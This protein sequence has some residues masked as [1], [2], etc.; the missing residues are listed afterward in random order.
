MQAFYF[1]VTY[2]FIFLIALLPFPILYK[3]SDF[4]YH[5]LRL[6][7]YR[8]EIV[9]KNLQN[10]FP[11]KSPSEIED[12]SQTYFRYLCDLT[13]ETLKTITM[14]SAEAKKHCVF[15]SATWLDDLYR[16]KKSIIIIMGHYGNWEW[17]GPSFSLNT[18]YQLIVIY[19]PLSNT[20]FENMM[21]TMRTKFGTCITPVNQTLRKMVACKDQVTA[22]AFIADQTA[23]QRDA[24]WTTFLNQET[25]VFT[26][27]EKLAIKFNYP[28]VYMNV[29]R[30]RR[31]YYEVSPELLF[32]QPKDTKEGEISE[33]F[34]NRLE[35]EIIRNPAFWLWSHRRWKHK[36]EIAPCLE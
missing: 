19:R 3:V 11:D 26:G 29:N 10:S 23:T 6:T 9:Y 4:L 31:G 21:S 22:T 30:I 35:K 25:A 2:P 15:K 8:K 1:Y 13:L 28:V 17:A 5:I 27:P 14:T 7:G 24:Y 33:A 12:L 34:T 32:A 20:Y 18:D 16:E 36:R